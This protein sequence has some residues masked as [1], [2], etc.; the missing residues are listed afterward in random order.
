MTA[1]ESYVG[2]G[3]ASIY[4]FGT[5]V[6]EGSTA[7]QALKVGKL[8]KWNV[9]TDQLYVHVI[10]PDGVTPV[11]V[12]GGKG[13]VRDN[14]FHPGKIDVLGTAGKNYE[15]HQNEEL[16]V[17]AQDVLD[18]SEAEVETAISVNGGRR[19]ILQLR[20]GQDILVG[21]DR[22]DCYLVASTGHTGSEAIRLFLSA[23]RFNCANQFAPA[24]KGAK[25]VYRIR[26][27]GKTTERIAD[28]RR[29]LDLSFAYVGTLQGEI[30]RLANSPFSEVQ[31]RAFAKRLHPVAPDA[32]DLVK[33][34]A[35]SRWA[36]WFHRFTQSDT[37]VGVEGT[38]WAAFNAI[39]EWADHFSKVNAAG[40]DADFVRS[41][42]ALLGGFDALKQEA[43]DKL[44]V[45]A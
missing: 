10:G 4:G 8:D 9:R 42:K 26:H 16:A 7:F 27:S 1:H 6:P 33:R 28:I 39:T 21:G 19:V 2:V 14:P 5:P 23:V 17:I 40:R 38:R 29:A 12:P 31:F 11:Q 25:S 32:T 20:L 37:I 41:E 18:N 13:I 43:W 45:R 34:N 22:T 30:E 35:E 36:E 3:R 24:L 15:A 44:L